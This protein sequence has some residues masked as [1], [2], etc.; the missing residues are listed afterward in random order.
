MAPQKPEKWNCNSPHSIAHAHALLL[1]ETSRWWVC[2]LAICHLPLGPHSRLRLRLHLTSRGAKFQNQD[3]QPKAPPPHKL[4]KATKTTKTHPS[5]F[6]RKLKQVVVFDVLAE[7][8][9]LHAVLP[10]AVLRKLDCF[11]VWSVDGTAERTCE[12]LRL[13]VVTVARAAARGA[14]AIPRAPRLA[15]GCW[16]GRTASR[17]RT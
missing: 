15:P 17:A 9:D 6:P 10:L 16:R 8:A 12:R 7:V 3:D 11:L 2:E 5:T 13:F 1:Q 4:K 14:T